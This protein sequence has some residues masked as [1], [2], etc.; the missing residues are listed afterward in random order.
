MIV[1]ARKI[2][3]V[4]RHLVVAG[5]LLP[6]A[7]AAVGDGNVVQNHGGCA[8]NLASGELRVHGLIGSFGLSGCITDGATTGTAGI[9]AS[10]STAGPVMTSASLRTIVSGRASR[11]VARTPTT[12]PFSTIALASATMHGASSSMRAVSAS[13]SVA[14]SIIIL[15]VE[16]RQR[17]AL[18]IFR[19]VPAEAD[20][21]HVERLL[22]LGLG[23]PRILI[24]P[25]THDHRHENA[26]AIKVIRRREPI[27]LGV[28]GLEYLVVEERAA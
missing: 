10:N 28:I 4:L 25:L 12:F 17:G 3:Q 19:V 18:G 2:A 22:L 21:D 15:L 1:A 20:L 8:K 24:Y 23:D 16:T 13:I 26:A 9:D 6:L 5:Q 14:L 11:S 27:K 7:G